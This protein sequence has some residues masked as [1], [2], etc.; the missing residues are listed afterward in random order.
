MCPCG[1]SS[2]IGARVGRSDKALAVRVPRRAPGEAMASK[3]A[4]G[5]PSG[6]APV[7]VHGSWVGQHGV[8]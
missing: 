1:S 5:L 8:R 3:A 4:V 2:T 6:A 7:F